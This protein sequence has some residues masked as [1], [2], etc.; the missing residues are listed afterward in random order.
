RL[1]SYKTLYTPSYVHCCHIPTLSPICFHSLSCCCCDL[2]HLFWLGNRPLGDH[3]G[4][5]WKRFWRNV[6]GS[7]WNSGLELDSRPYPGSNYRSSSF[8][9]AL[10]SGRAVPIIQG[11]VQEVLTVNRVAAN[12]TEFRTFSSLKYHLVVELKSL[13][14]ADIFRD[15]VVAFV[16]RV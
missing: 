10:T 12:F 13:F 5:H 15:H 3:Y 7:G 6:R 16:V 1:N 14:D 2:K 11:G 9:G 8:P 4:R